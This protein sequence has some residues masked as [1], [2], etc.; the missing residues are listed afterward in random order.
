MSRFKR[1]LS[2]K[3]KVLLCDSIILSRFNYCDAVYQNIDVCLQRKVQKVQDMCCRFIFN[4]KRSDHCNYDEMRKKLGWLSMKQRRELHSLTMM[5]KILHGL[6]PNYLADLFSY[7]KEIHNFNT[8]GSQNDNIWIDKSITSKIH[9]NSFKYH[10]ACQYNKLP[11]SIRECK[12]VNSFKVN[13]TK[14][15]KSDFIL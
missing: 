2:T 1:F 3:S 13:L 10:T 8:R 7:Q 11:S 14:L 12:S 15:L 5:Y 6:A 9:R 4:L